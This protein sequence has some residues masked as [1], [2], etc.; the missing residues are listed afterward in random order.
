MHQVCGEIILSKDVAWGNRGRIDANYDGNEN[1]LPVALPEKNGCHSCQEAIDFRRPFPFYC[2][3]APR[4]IPGFV[5]P[6]RE[7]RYCMRYCTTTLASAGLVV[8]PAAA[9]CTNTCSEDAAG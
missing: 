9:V 3:K 1:P 4:S 8:Q 5:M 2:N 6:A 7:P